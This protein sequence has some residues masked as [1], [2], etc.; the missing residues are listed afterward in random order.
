MAE[1]ALYHYLANN[2]HH[3]DHPVLSDRHLRRLPARGGSGA[4]QAARVAG[5]MMRRQ[6]WCRP[7]KL[8]LGLVMAVNAG[9]ANATLGQSP[10]VFG[11]VAASTAVPAPRMQA[12]TPVAG[13]SLYVQHAVQLET[14]TL[15][16]EYA[17]PTGIVFAV[18][19]QGPVLPDLGALLGHYFSTF[20]LAT[21]RARLAGR[22]GGPVS[23]K[24]ADLVMQSGGRMRDFFGHAY[25]PDLIPAGVD[26]KDVLP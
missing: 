2:L 4:T 13:S 17:T 19:W 1:Q 23:I 22:R 12:V 20:E 6:P 8:L 14:G 9:A 11:A 3:H 21:E 15:V 16:R 26:I 10:G 25:A 5:S 24:Q 7:L 18:S